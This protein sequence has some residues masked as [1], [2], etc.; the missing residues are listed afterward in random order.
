MDTKSTVRAPTTPYQ[1]LRSYVGARLQR[2]LTAWLF[3]TM[4]L[5]A[6][7][8]G[9]ASWMAGQLSN[10]APGSRFENVHRLVVGQLALVWDNPTARRELIETLSGEAHMRVE[11]RDTAGTLVD[12]TGSK[13]PTRLDRWPSVQ[14]EGR[15]LGTIHLCVPRSDKTRIFVG[16]GLAVLLLAAAARLFARRIAL[17]LEEVARVAE[18]VSAGNLD[19]KSP[20]EGK[21]SAWHRDVQLVAETLA[22]MA[23]QVARQLRE[24][25]EL[26]AAV[27]HELRTP[28]GH[29]R[30][31]LEQMRGDGPLST[32]QTRLLAQCE[33]EVLD[34][35]AMVGQLLA[36][37]RLEFRELRKDSVN[38]V[39]LAIEKLE[40]LGLDPTLLDVDGPHPVVVGDATLLKRALANLLDNA[41]RHGHGTKMLRI[42]S[43]NGRAQVEVEDDGPGFAPGEAERA[44]E[45]FHGAGHNAENL[46]LGLH[47]VAKI[48]EAHG[49]RAYAGNGE[50][51]G[52]VVGIELPLLA[53]A[54]RKA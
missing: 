33:R 25:R 21:R 10:N 6:A 19:V 27:S 13:C 37:A 43:S 54:D 30:L 22:D 7:I 39:D 17:P 36:N 9:G 44:F 38:L 47:L 29:L 49:G 28:L 16:L 32:E 8:A 42:R 2:R 11:L 52:A 50:Q 18:S 4:V 53:S 20:F 45:P 14:R 35:D 1:R 46:G 26:L 41:R 24:Q 12:A 15:E 48:A 5:T 23:S 31:L 34:I 3:A 40:R 51:R